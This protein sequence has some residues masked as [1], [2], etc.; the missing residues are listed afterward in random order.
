[1]KSHLPFFLFI[2]LVCTGSLSYGQGTNFRFITKA[3]T[4]SEDTT[5]ILGP[6]YKRALKIYNKLAEARGDKRFPLPAFTMS[7]SE[8][9]V[10]YLEGDGLSIGLEEKAYDICMSYGEE[11]GENAIA[12]LLGHELTHFYEKHQWRS[13]FADA[14]QDLQ[15]GADL[16]QTIGLDKLNNETQSDYLGGFLAYSAGYQVFENLP[17]FYDD[18]YQSYSL[19][20]KMQGYA[21]KSDRKALAVKSTEAVQ[22]LIEVYEMANLLTAIGR[23]NDARVFFK[24]ILTQY[25]GREVYNNL[26]VL[27]I[28]EAMTYLSKEEKKYR[29]PIE[30]DLTF[31]SA[32]RDGAVDAKEKKMKA[33][34]EEALR[35]LDNAISMDKAYAPAYLNKA[36]VYYLLKD[37]NRARFYGNVE[38]RQQARLDRKKFRSTLLNCN[39]LNALILYQTGKEDKAIEILEKNKKNSALAA[40]NLGVMKA[41][42]NPKVK[43][44]NGPEDE[45]I[46][47]IEFGNIYAFTRSSKN[48]RSKEE[49]ELFGQIDF[50]KWENTGGL[51][52]STIY[53]C[54]APPGEEQPDIYFHIT[55][56]GY[57]GENF[58]EEFRVGTPRKAITDIYGEPGFSLETPNGQI[59]VYEEMLI[60]LD[61]GQKVYRWASY[62]LKN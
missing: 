29:I 53:V 10:A 39:V 34:L 41:L 56:A 60:M 36:C 55:D 44:P 33:L 4:E 49:Q 23:Y 31:G 43:K 12:A 48:R 62:F 52:E 50:R 2:F 9:W 5:K 19:P 57:S 30:L 24:H 58:Y 18:L 21:S 20:E 37:Y 47:G 8:R 7:G 42:P 51:T 1:M 61:A 27:T 13:G 16:N 3:N 22:K 6:K 15:V 17:K 40:Y 28:L 32:T 59:M 38:A 35:Y 14:F 26:A 25:Q 11:K 45:E 54:K 46:D